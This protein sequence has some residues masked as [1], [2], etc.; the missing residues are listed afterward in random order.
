MITIKKRDKT[1]SKKQ[2][3]KKEKVNIYKS[4]FNTLNN[5][6]FIASICL[7]QL[8]IYRELRYSL[9]YS[10]SFKA[11]FTDHILAYRSYTLP[12]SAFIVIYSRLKRTA[13]KYFIS[14]IIFSVA[15]NI[16]FSI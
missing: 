7:S 14:L 13:I 4:T 3:K 8:R 1:K 15:R 6:I 9:H 16:T 11:L 5:I 10:A 2:K 12:Q